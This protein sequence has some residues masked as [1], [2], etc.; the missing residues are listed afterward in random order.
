MHTT[1]HKDAIHQSR[2]MRGLK[3]E[4]VYRE[5]YDL[6]R[7]QRAYAKLYV[8]DGAMTPGTTPETVDGMSVDKMERIISTLRDGS[9]RWKP[10][11]RIY[12][13]KKNGKMRPLGLPTWTDKLVQEVIRSILGPYFE[14]KFRDSSHGFRPARGCHTAL[15]RCKQK[16]RGANW[17]IE[18]DI[19][20]C[21]DNINHRVL[22]DIL[23][24]SI[25]DERFLRLVMNMLEAGYLEE[26]T[27]RETH[28]GTPQGG[29][30]SPL[31]A[32]I[33]LHKL[34]EFVEDVL[35]PQ[36]TR[37]KARRINPAYNAHAKA[38]LKAKADDDAESWHRLK[39][40]QRSIP[41]SMPRDEKFRRLSYVR[42]A[43][44]FIL[45]FMGPKAEAED[46]K[47]KIKA[48]LA[49]TLKLEL[50]E[51]KTL[52]SHAT[53]EPA[54][55]LGYDIPVMKDDGKMVAASNSI[56]GTFNK[57]SINGI[58]RLTVPWEKIEAHCRNYTIDGKIRKRM[59]QMANE[60]FSIVA[61]YG[62][63]FRGVAQYYCMAH[64]RARKLSKLKYV[65]Q[66]S[67]LKT[68]AAKHKT[69]V[70][71][72][73]K[74]YR[75]ERTDLQ[76]MTPV[77]AY[78]VEVLRP[79]KRSLVA[80]FGGFSLKRQDKEIIEDQISRNRNGRT[81][82][83][84]RLMADKCENC[85]STGNCEVHHVRKLADLLKQKKNRPGWVHMMILRSRKT[86][87][88]CQDCHAALHAGR[89]V[90]Q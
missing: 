48:F 58:V 84:E 61:W 14:A 83:L 53:T 81:E 4:R 37:G 78:E 59:D 21:F 16:F 77:V 87:V 46:I 52:I 86:L 65:M 75:A 74:K 18:G 6:D 90:K 28:S 71:V 5:L 45:G 54:R 22:M 44:D 64:D 3:L 51:E 72:M 11:K 47:S 25:D 82:I 66:T 31:L 1:Q 49:D 10:T 32:N 13:P 68:L 62:I 36:Y 80:T 2:G 34:D 70:D 23:R 73:A 57:R 40:E 63:V 43:D 67:M 88:L 26:W 85:G 27:R 29:V 39:I 38:M 20:G 19:K 89:Y 60:D 50:S 69:T 12:I 55:F 15:A 9:F 24:E 41:C 8:N 17:F 7:F 76:T 35:Q 56:M 30:I 33:Y 79:G 42:Y